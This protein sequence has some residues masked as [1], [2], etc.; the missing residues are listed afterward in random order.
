MRHSWMALFVWGCIDAPPQRQIP[1]LP[2][3]VLSND[4]ASRLLFFYRPSST[5]G[6]GEP[7]LEHC[8]VIASARCSNNEFPDPAIQQICSAA[9]Q[10]STITTGT[11]VLSSP[12]NPCE[13]TT[14]SGRTLCLLAQIDDTNHYTAMQTIDCDHLAQGLN[15]FNAR[16]I[17]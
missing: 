12:A 5:P 3:G 13:L 15:P 14:T 9:G 11:F 2:D 16:W 7:A 1:A 10:W 17:P 8:Y 6:T 4:P